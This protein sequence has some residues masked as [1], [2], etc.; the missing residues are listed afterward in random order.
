MLLLVLFTFHVLILKY[1]L[2]E[3]IRTDYLQRKK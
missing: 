2:K 3:Q 1:L